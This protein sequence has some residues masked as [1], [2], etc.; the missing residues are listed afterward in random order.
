MIANPRID[1]RKIRALARSA[2]RYIRRFLYADN[3]L[4]L[5]EEIARRYL[6]GSGIEIGALHLPLVVPPSTH[7]RYID[8]MPTEQLREHYPELADQRLVSIDI[9]DNGERISSISD[10]S[11]DFVIANHMIEHT[12]DPILALHNWLR[13]IKP[14][15]MLYMGVPHKHHTFDQDRPVTPLE[16]II[17]DHAEGPEWSRRLHFEEW[18]RFV[19]K[20][21]E[22]EIEARV[23]HLM[24]IDYSIPFP[25][26]TEIEFLELLL[27]CRNHL[28]FPFAIEMFQMNGVEFIILLRKQAVSSPQ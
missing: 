6:S 26:W 10:E 12:Q 8:R 20:T 23:Q 22:G 18:A 28:V 24:N 4:R 11:V 14:H 17:R 15:G 3:R 16:H 5:R 21:P 1:S 2:K 25:V 9:I 13:V 19:N 27:F 7:V